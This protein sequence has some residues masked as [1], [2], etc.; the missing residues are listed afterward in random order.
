MKT[1]G[2]T[3]VELL[4]V[5]SFIGIIAMIVVPN[6]AGLMK[7]VDE[8]KYKSFLNDVYL[9]TE[10][11]IQKNSST[12]TSLQ[13][14]GTE[15]VYL[16]QLVNSKLLK[17]TVVN[18]KKNETIEKELDYTIIV[19]KNEDSG[20]RYELVEEKL[21]VYKETILNGTDPIIKGDLVAVTIENDRTVKKANLKS[22]WYSY[23]NKK[24]ANAVI[25]KDK[26][27]TY[28]DNDIIPEENI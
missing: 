28:S 17:S 6:I 27:V 22:K 19:T 9:A 23:E 8:N 2:F 5:M 18:P 15:Y 12:Y 24:W 26:T 16:S 11:Y 10:A 3:F 13:N 25:L 1:K 21:I 7:Q 14:G 20:Y 4:V